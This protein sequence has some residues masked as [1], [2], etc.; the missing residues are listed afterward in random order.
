MRTPLWANPQ[1]NTAFTDCYAQGFWL[2]SLT[3]SWLIP[4]PVPQ[5]FLTTFLTLTVIFFS[6]VPWV[7][8]LIFPCRS[9]SFMKFLWLVAWGQLKHLARGSACCCWFRTRFVTRLSSTKGWSGRIYYGSDLS[10][11]L[12]ITCFTGMK[13]GSYFRTIR[14]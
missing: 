11:I 1:T 6:T 7:M 14:T 5:V 3:S 4:A 8:R 2:P 9:V 13:W 12:K 10:S